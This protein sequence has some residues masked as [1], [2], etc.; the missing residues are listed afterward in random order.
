GEDLRVL[1]AGYDRGSRGGRDEQ[2]V[3]LALHVLQHHRAPR[4]TLAPVDL[5]ARVFEGLGVS[6]GNEGLHHLLEMIPRYRRGL[7]CFSRLWVLVSGGRGTSGEGQGEDEEKI[8]P[9]GGILPSF[10]VNC[11]SMNPRIAIAGMLV[12]FAGCATAPKPS[13]PPIDLLAIQHDL[14]MD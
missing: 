2:E 14:A 7:G 3:R 11:N 12:V 5:N 9:H 1:D 8:N 10:E 4:D 13:A 6:G